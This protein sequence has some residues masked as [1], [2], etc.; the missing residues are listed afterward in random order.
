MPVPMYHCI[1]CGVCDQMV[2]VGGL[3]GYTPTDAV[4]VA[5]TV[6]YC[7]PLYATCTI[8]FG[9]CCCITALTTL[10]WFIPGAFS[11]SIY[12]NVL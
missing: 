5:I 7:H 2:V 11:I 6:L 9:G 8:V 10:V 1:V 3:I 12:Y 4:C